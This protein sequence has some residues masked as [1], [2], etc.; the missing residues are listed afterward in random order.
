MTISYLNPVTLV[1]KFYSNIKRDV[2]IVNIAKRILNVLF[3]CMFSFIWFV[4]NYQLNHNN[5]ILY[6]YCSYNRKL[7]SS[8]ARAYHDKSVTIPS[9]FFIRLVLLYDGFHLNR[10][11]VLIKSW[12]WNYFILKSNHL[13]FK[14]YLNKK[15]DVKIC[16]YCQKNFEGFVLLYVLIS[17]DLLKSINKIMTLNFFQFL[18]L[19]QEISNHQAH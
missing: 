8:S 17:F 5:K 14:F 16:K 3:C 18:L 1:F 13:V 2:R 9:R 12:Q 15:R 10:C 19:K 7:P 4:K 6:C 11:K